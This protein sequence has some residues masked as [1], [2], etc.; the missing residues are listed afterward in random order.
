[1]EENPIH[2]VHQGGRKDQ[3]QRLA[4]AFVALVIG[5]VLLIAGGIFSIIAIMGL[6]AVLAFIG[7]ALTGSTLRNYLTWTP[8]EKESN[9]E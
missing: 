4:V 1:M 2:Q 3:E 9:H 8:I 6:G 7:L 5:L